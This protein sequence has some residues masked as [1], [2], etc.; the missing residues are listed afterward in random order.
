MPSAGIRAL[1]A[2]IL[3]AAG[4]SIAAPAAAQTI[5][6]ALL[7]VHSTILFYPTGTKSF[8]L[9]LLVSTSGY[10]QV[11]ETEANTINPLP[12]RLYVA[13]SA[14]ASAET[15]A[16]LRSALNA[17]QIGI[18]QSCVVNQ[19]FIVQGTVEITWYGRNLRRNQFTVVMS[20]RPS[21]LPPCPPDLCGILQAIKTY[22]RA[23]TP[24]NGIPLLHCPGP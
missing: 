11:W 6:Q 13:K 4:T 20:D 18:Q 21:D 22:A 17:G 2:L 9:D 12:L 16:A 1:A 3:V 14:T 5:S 15:L 8:D 19:G 10:S 23:L 7:R 24:L